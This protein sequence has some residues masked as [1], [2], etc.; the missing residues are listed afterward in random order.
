MAFVK[1]VKHGAKLRMNID[2]PSGSGKTYTALKVARALVGSTGKVAVLDSEH[3]SATKYAD[4]FD[5]DTDPDF[6]APYHPD[7]Y[8][9][10]IK[11]AEDGGY[12]L[13]II[14]SLSHAWAGQGGLLEEKDKIAKRKQGNSYVAWGDATPIQN[15]MV[16]AIL[17]SNIHVIVTLRSKMDY[18]QEEVDGKK[19]VRKI[20]L[21]PVQRDGI[22]Y[23]FDVTL[24]M[25]LD[26]CGCVGK[27]RCTALDGKVF[28]RPGEEVAGLLK[29]W[30]DG[31]PPPARPKRT[32]TETKPAAPA[33]SEAKP[34]GNGKPTGNG[35]GGPSKAQMDRLTGWVNDSTLPEATR[36]FIADKLA[37]GLDSRAAGAFIGGIKKKIEEMVHPPATPPAGSDHPDDQLPDMGGP[38]PEDRE[39]GCEG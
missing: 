17:A 28:D 29:A 23:E 38:P 36:K 16:E 32:D 1:A 2:G 3:G 7:K 14:D 35:N 24:S 13:I 30:L 18:V 20:G 15:R 8:V 25:D 26:H 34:A 31:D 33:T 27:T 37:K 22:E 12:D 11:A 6:G 39:P 21:A 9:A 4:Q 10:G 19:K 5:F